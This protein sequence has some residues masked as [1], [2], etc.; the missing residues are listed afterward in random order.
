MKVLLSIK[1]EFADKIFDG[2][3]KFEFRRTIFSKTHINT[4]IVYASSPV[5]RVIGEFEISQVLFDDIDT[6]WRRT[7]EYAGIDEDYFFKYFS[8]RHKGYAIEIKKVKKYKNPM[9]LQERFQIQPPQSFA[10][11]F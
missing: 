3:K 11:I 8:D 4:V 6:L 2:T 1:P 9:Q 5:Q 10:Y 7:R